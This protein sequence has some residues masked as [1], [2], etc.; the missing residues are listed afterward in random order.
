MAG[1]TRRQWPVFG[2]LVVVVAAIALTPARSVAAESSTVITMHDP[3]LTEV[4]GIARGLRSPG[5]FYVQN[6][7]GD[8]ARYFAVDVHTGR[9]RAVY[10]VP[11]ATN[12]D[13]EDLAVAPDAAGVP[14]VWLGDIG[15]ND[16]QRSEVRVYRVDEPRVPMNRYDVGTRTD[17]PD[18][19]RLRYPDGPVNAESL[20]VSPD[21]RGYIFTKSAAGD[22]VCYE[23]P[24]HPDPARVQVLHRVGGFQIRARQSSFIPADLQ[25]MATGAAISPDGTVLVLRT[26]TDA[27]LWHVEHGNV[28]R[29]LRTKPQ[30]LLLPLQPQ[31]EGIG[32]DGD[33]L[34]IDSEGDSSDVLAV[35]LPAAFRPNDA[36]PAPG[37]RTSNTASPAPDSGTSATAQS[38]APANNHI[39]LGLGWRILIAVVSIVLGCIL[40]A[41]MIARRRRRPPS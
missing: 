17:R 2:A 11:G 35:P 8:S 31:G 41:R 10:H 16:A 14:S 38:P 34:V 24:P 9:V 15:D 33:S 32:F 27:F 23:L 39:D 29:A 12:V 19:W 6:D 21:G 3:R 36:P 37:V 40:L 20:A 5:V 4:S 7:S 30:R 22:S 26:Y 25:Q 28:A 13:W 18:V 1:V